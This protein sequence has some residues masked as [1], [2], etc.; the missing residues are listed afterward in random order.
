MGIFSHFKEQEDRLD[1][2]ETHVRFMTETVQ[3]NQ[4]DVAAGMVALLVLQGRIDEKVSAADV[5][6][7]VKKINQEIG[8]AREQYHAA[9][10]SAAESWSKMQGG[11]QDALASLRKSVDDA[12]AR[13]EQG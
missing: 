12:R 1:A 11:V 4:M 6:P 5:D 9:S 10:E 13:V 7:V 2:L 8:V 3:Q